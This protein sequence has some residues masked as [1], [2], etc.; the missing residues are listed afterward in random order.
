MKKATSIYKPTI[1]LTSEPKISNDFFKV[2][3][4]SITYIL[5]LKLWLQFP[6]ENTFLSISTWCWSLKKAFIILKALQLFSSVRERICPRD[7]AVLKGLQWR[8]CVAEEEDYLPT[9]WAPQQWWWVLQPSAEHPGQ[10]PP[11]SPHL[12]TKQTHSESTKCLWGCDLLCQR[13]KVKLP[14]LWNSAGKD[15][16]IEQGDRRAERC[17]F[18]F[19]ASVIQVKW[20]QRPTETE[21]CIPNPITLCASPSDRKLA[22]VTGLKVWTQSEP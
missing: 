12:G 5:H 10:P 20:E 19:V 8:M 7:S 13:V 6:P 22:P 17:S 15:E 21:G 1:G 14:P 16:R 4:A 18:S 3:K 9:W 2:E 11:L